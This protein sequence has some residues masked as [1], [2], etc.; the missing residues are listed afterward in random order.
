MEVDIVYSVIDDVTK[1]M[2]Q[3]VLVTATDPQTGD[4]VNL[5]PNHYYD[6]INPTRLYSH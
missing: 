1:L 4:M 5:E 6:F 2:V 3:M